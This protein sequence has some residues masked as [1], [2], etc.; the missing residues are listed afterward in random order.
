MRIQ[1][2]LYFQGDEV[3]GG[4]SRGCSMFIGPAVEDRC[5]HQGTERGIWMPGNW[6]GSVRGGSHFV[7]SLSPRRR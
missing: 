4:H 7:Q 2:K 1:Y 3:A 5:E 6:E